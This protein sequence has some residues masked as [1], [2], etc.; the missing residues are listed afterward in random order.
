M[1]KAKNA[2]AETAGQT[3][4]RGPCA[5]VF[6]FSRSLRHR[7][8]AEQPMAQPVRLLVAAPAGLNLRRGPTKSYAV[9]AVLPEGSVVTVLDLPNDVEV[10][11]GH[12]CPARQAPAG[13]QTSSCCRRSE[14]WQS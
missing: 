8:P 9:L 12:W 14:P 13:W 2:A 11:G 3:V 5:A 4:G 10:P 1:S 7:P 6:Q